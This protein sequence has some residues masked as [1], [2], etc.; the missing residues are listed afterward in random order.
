MLH[1]HFYFRLKVTC[2]NI[3][4]HFIEPN[5]F[6]DSIEY[7]AWAIDTD[8]QQLSQCFQVGWKDK[9]CSQPLFKS[10]TNSVGDVRFHLL[11]QSVCHR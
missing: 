8:N 9:Q 4:L 5:Q 11:M 7:D 3:F 6:V 2:D 1:V 10:Y